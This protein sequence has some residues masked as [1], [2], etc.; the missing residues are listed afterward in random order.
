MRGSCYFVTQQ[1][2][3]NALFGSSALRFPHRLLRYGC[4][5][6][7]ARTRN[8]QMG[9]GTASG[10][11][12]SPVKQ[13]ERL[14]SGRRLGLVRSETLL[15]STCM[16]RYMASKYH[17]APKAPTRC[18][19]LKWRDQQPVV[20]DYFRADPDLKC[21]PGMARPFFAVRAQQD[22]QGSLRDA[23]HH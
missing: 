17:Q 10:P 20:L 13:A 5:P 18:S 8:T 14:Y 12:W 1:R 23:P 7:E 2:L 3:H 6:A 9:W 4:D 16:L 21:R 11:T 19:L 22:L 15:W